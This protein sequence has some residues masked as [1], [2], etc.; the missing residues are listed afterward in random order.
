MLILWLLASY[1]FA[2]I[3]L[4][5]CVQNFFFLSISLSL[6]PSLQMLSWPPWKLMPRRGRSGGNSARKRP[7]SSKRWATKRS[8]KTILK[9]RLSI[10]TRYCLCVCICVCV[11]VSQCLL[12]TE[13]GERVWRERITRYSVRVSV[14]L[15]VCLSPSVLLRLSVSQC[16][17]TSVCLPVFCYI[18]LSPSVLLHLSVTQCFVT[19]VCHPVFCYGKGTG[20]GEKI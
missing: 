16:F 9:K 13:G 4:A 18:C 19:S 14:C 2:F 12:C 5:S 7:R 20:D 17:V 1:L 3:H 11:S 8:R 10:I 15:S 6:S